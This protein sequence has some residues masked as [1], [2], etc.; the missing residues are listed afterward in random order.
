MTRKLLATNIN[1]SLDTKRFIEA[2]ADIGVTLLDAHLIVDSKESSNSAIIEVSG[3]IAKK[4][5]LGGVY[6]INGRQ[7]EFGVLQEI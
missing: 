2:L 1:P 3:E 4:L 7:I 6:C 5:L